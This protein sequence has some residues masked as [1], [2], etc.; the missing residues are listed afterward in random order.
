MFIIEF[1]CT[2]VDMD[3]G[4]LL[5]TSLDKIVNE[6]ISP[7]VWEERNLFPLFQFQR[8]N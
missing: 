3:C 7:K 1:A 6:M 8:A 5:H 4:S 2:K